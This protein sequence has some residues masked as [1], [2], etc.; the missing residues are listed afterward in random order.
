MGKYKLI[1]PRSIM[2][3]ALFLPLVGCGRHDAQV[4]APTTKVVTYNPLQTPIIHV[5][6]QVTGRC[7][8][9][10]FASVRRDAY[11]CS[12]ADYS[13]DP[14]LS[15]SPNTL[16]CPVDVFD[17][18]GAI[19]KLDKPLPSGRTLSQNQEAWAMLLASG[20]H[21]QAL[22]AFVDKKFPF[23]CT[24]GKAMCAMPNLPKA[25][26]AYFVRCGEPEADSVIDVTS[27]LVKIAYR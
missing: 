17:R 21:C 6:L 25:S 7:K 8:V 20:A 1:L 14:C 5:V 10:R 13:F 9:S 3:V 2:I 26:P 4:E 12:A 16:R 19:V 24:R 18:K 22:T 27:I 23:A 11:R 15:A